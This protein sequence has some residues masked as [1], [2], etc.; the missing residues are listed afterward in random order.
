MDSVSVLLIEDH[1]GEARLNQRMLERSHTMEFRFTSRRTL[2]EAKDVFANSSFDVL[3][4]DLNLPD[5]SGIGTYEQMQALAP[6]LP[7]VIISAVSDERLAVECIRRGAQDY[8]VKA[9]ITS[10]TMTR[11]VR[12]AMARMGTQPL[13][14]VAGNSIGDRFPTVSFPLAGRARRQRLASDRVPDQQALSA[15]GGTEGAGL[16]QWGAQFRH[17]DEHRSRTRLTD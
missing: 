16:C 8:L 13:R 6:K 7:I 12:H 4:L 1:E 10:E 15:V 17:R 9:S 11:V 14:P 3:L 5:S 2:A